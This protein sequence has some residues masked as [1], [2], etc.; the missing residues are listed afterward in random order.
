MSKGNYDTDG[1]LNETKKK[2]F[3]HQQFKLIKQI[4]SQNQMKKL[5]FF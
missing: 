5:N 3:G 2:K 1:E 4:R